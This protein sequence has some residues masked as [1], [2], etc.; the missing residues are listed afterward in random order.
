MFGIGLPEMIVIFAVALIVVGPDKLPDMA[1]SLAKGIMEMKKAANQIKD[2]LTEEDET[3]S[4]VKK[5][6][7]ETAAELKKRMIDAETRITERQILEDKNSSDTGELIELSPENPRPWEI[8]ARTVPEES[9]DELINEAELTAS[10]EKKPEEEINDVE[11]TASTE[12]KPEEE[13]KQA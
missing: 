13:E 3:I 9:P 12:E 8:D 4:D 5:D 6:L 10:T 7:Q 1:K 11:L 2:N